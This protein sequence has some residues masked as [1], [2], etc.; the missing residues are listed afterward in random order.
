MSDAEKPL[1]TFALF[2]Y[3]QEK[4]IREAVE[5]AFSQTYEPLEIILS[6]DCSSDRTF[7]IMQEMVAAY[8][9]PHRVRMRRSEKNAG[10]AEHIN[11]VAKIVNGDIV[12]VAAGDDVSIK[13]RV[14]ILAQTFR[15]DPT[16]FAVLSNYSCIPEAAALSGNRNPSSDPV[17]P[18][19]ILANGGG[20]QIGATYAYRRPCFTWPANLPD[21]LQCEDRLLPF[22]ASLLGRVRYVDNILIRYRIS[23]SHL[24]ISLKQS[25]NHHYKDLRHFAALEECV[26]RAGKDGLISF[27]KQIYLKVLILF[28]KKSISL[29]HKSG[30][31]KI[32]GHSMHIGI[33]ACRKVSVISSRMLLLS[34]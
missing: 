28:L 15:S 9:G 20:V 1:V 3:N 30:L 23:V 27:P 32:I 24:E 19:E 7:E 4:Y 6:D 25:R 17:T 26:N 29:R 13:N 34:I 14:D 21:W 31:S 2:A 11:S 33:R 18:T 5:G 16:A 8:E 12:V 10:L 22:R